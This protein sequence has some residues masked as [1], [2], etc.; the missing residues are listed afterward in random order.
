MLHAAVAAGKG[1]FVVG[2]GVVMAVAT[3]GV[4]PGI[5]A[6]QLLTGGGGI[7]LGLAILKGASAVGRLTQL[8]ENHESRLSRLERNE[9]AVR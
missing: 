3:G 1:V 2:S 4:H 8:V 6:G 5:T 7:I 9:D